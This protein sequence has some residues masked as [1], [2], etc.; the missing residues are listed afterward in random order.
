[1]PRGLEDQD[2]IWRFKNPLQEVSERIGSAP[3]LE[4]IIETVQGKGY[5]LNSSIRIVSPRQ[6]QRGTG[7]GTEA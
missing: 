4:A 6:I 5:R 7:H 1:M 3:G 2:L